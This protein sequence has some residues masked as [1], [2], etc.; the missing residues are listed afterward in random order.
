MT[1]AVPREVEVVSPCCLALKGEGQKFPHVATRCRYSSTEPAL[2]RSA[3]RTALFCWSTHL[4][5]LTLPEVTLASL[6][7]AWLLMGFSFTK[8]GTRD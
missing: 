8:A 7:F 3:P 1:L 6:A 4:L 5:S 2:S